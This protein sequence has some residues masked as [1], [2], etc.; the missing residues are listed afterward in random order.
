MVD[1]IAAALIL[2]NYLDF[3]NQRDG[4]DNEWRR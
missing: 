3:I 2:Q 1:K 4:E